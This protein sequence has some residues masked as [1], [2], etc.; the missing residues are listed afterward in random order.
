MKV[1]DT[2]LIQKSEGRRL[3]KYHL[4]IECNDN[5]I[6]M[7]E[8]F[9]TTMAPFKVKEE[10]TKENNWNGVYST[11]YKDKHQRWL[12]KLWHCFWKLWNKYDDF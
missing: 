12:D 1:V 5:D 2:K 8:D 6:L 10:P 7:L 11:D 9:A 3:G 4:T